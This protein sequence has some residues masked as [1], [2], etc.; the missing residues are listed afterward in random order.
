MTTFSKQ[1]K[2]Q[3]YANIVLDDISLQI[4]TLKKINQNSEESFQENMNELMKIIGSNIKDWNS[5]SIDNDVEIMRYLKMEDVF[6]QTAKNTLSQYTIVATYSL[7]EKGLKKILSLAGFPKNFV[8]GDAM[9]TKKLSNKLI[10]KGVN[11]D[12][13]NEFQSINE[14]RLIN[15]CVKHK[16]IV[17]PELAS[18]YSKWNEGEEFFDLSTDFLRLETIPIVLLGKL[19]KELTTIV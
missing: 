4:S 14:L 5:I 2:F 1:Q 10:G 15:N 16:G 13:S 12:F 3:T 9:C 11:C 17:N 8:N 18:N 7:Y 6:S 19:I